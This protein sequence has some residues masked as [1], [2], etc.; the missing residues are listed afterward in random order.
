MP[1]PVK[2]AAV[3]LLLTL[4]VTPGTLWAAPDREELHNLMA[5]VARGARGQTEPD[6]AVLR[7]AEA[8]ARGAL[9]GQDGPA[10]ALTAARAEGLRDPWIHPTTLVFDELPPT[11]ALTSILASADVPWE[12]TTHG[13][14]GLASRG[15][16]TAV[17]FLAVERLARFARDQ[18]TLPKGT[19]AARLLVLSPLGQ[20][21]RREL[22][23]RR[24]SSFTLDHGIEDIAGAWV[25]Q[26]EAVAPSGEARLAALWTVRKEKP[27][28]KEPVAADN[29]L[30]LGPG[31]MGGVDRRP[32][33]DSADAWI[34]GSDDAP[35]RAPTQQDAERV[36]DYLRSVLASQ[37][38]VLR[39]SP[40]LVDA[41]VTRVARARSASLDAAVE[42]VA[43]RLVAAGLAPLSADEIVLSATSPVEALEFLLGSGSS[44]DLLL[45]EQPGAYGVGV[46]LQGR[47]G[48]W[49]LAL[50]LIRAELGDGGSLRDIFVEHVSRGRKAAAVGQ[51]LFRPSLDA[52]AARA[53]GIVGPREEARLTDAERTALVSE[54]RAAFP[55]TRSVAFDVLFSS[56]PSAIALR[57]RLAEGR[58]SEAGLAVDDAG[59][60]GFVTV[61]V[62]VSR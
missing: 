8:I 18:V 42:P 50:T 35:S 14:V 26:L 5:D 21:E 30:G 1:H 17:C 15:G 12:R 44:R 10:L 22:L 37:R 46:T 11:A 49:S 24:G 6:E 56:D 39:L 57:P 48:E 23:P 45:A 20:L 47:A 60:S 4:L 55:D 38:R 52:V 54:V 29:P 31:G 16:R 53:A 9:D 58:W 7:T 28:P 2:A 13:A 62:L 51:L 34:A 27:A 3:A 43:N 40:F 61:L 25:L 32:A 19:V 59:A 41:A 36:E 33:P